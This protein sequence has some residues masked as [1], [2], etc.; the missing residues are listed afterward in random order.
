[1]LLVSC[2]GIKEVTEST[3]HFDE[4]AY[5]GEFVRLH[6]D[7]ESIQASIIHN[8]RFYYCFV[9]YTADYNMLLIFVS[10]SIDDT[11]IQYIRI[12]LDFYVEVA[13]FSIKDDDTIAL[14]A[15]E[16][17]YTQTEISKVIF[18]AEYDYS[19]KEL[20]RKN[21]KHDFLKSDSIFDNSYAVITESGNIA[22][23]LRDDN[24]SM[25]LYIFNTTED[26]VNELE[27]KS[28]SRKS[29]ALL[30]D[31]RV[32]AIDSDNAVTVLR[33]IDFKAK[34][35]GKAYPV[36]GNSDMNL[37]AAGGLAYDFLLSD[38][39]HLYGYTIETGEQMKILSWMECGFT[40]A[41]YSQIGALDD[42]R[43]TIQYSESYGGGTPVQ[44]LFVLN[45]VLRAGLPEQIVITL[46]GIWVTSEIK[47]VVAAFNRAH[48]NYRIDIIEYTELGLGDD[49]ESNWRHG[50][51]LLQT[52]LMTGRG[53]DIIYDQEIKAAFLNTT[54]DLYPFIDA[55][56]QFDRVD[57]FPNMLAALE[58]R[59]GTLSM[60][61]NHFAVTTIVGTAESVGHITSWTPAQ[62]LS[63]VEQSQNM[64]YPLGFHQSK[65][66]FVMSFLLYSGANFINMD[67][68]GVD[69]DND[70]FIHILETAKMLPEDNYS[71]GGGRPG[72]LTRLLEANQILSTVRLTEILDFRIM[73]EYLGDSMIILGMPSNAGG[74]HA[75]SQSSLLGINA[76]SQHSD[77]AWEFIRGFLLPSA[78][79]N[80]WQG[81]PLRIDLF[82]ALIKDAKTPILGLDENGNTV[83]VP[84][85][86]MFMSTS[87]SLSSGDLYNL[88][89]YAL[90]E[91]QA[92]SL[93][94]II[95]SAKSRM[96]FLEPSLTDLISEDLNTY[97]AGSRTVQETV[98]IMQNR[99]ATY[100]SEQELINR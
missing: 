88:K 53:P 74:M 18:Y 22:L 50:H 39:Q 19:G 35:W 2:G 65:T 99:I 4:Y 80:N 91:E 81:F 58:N 48:L 82:E 96:R 87:M 77:V 7:I 97:F 47:S 90:A 45:T 23:T 78:K 36:A 85:L 67:I 5:I 71:L 72:E 94:N 89:I 55:D 1:M 37:F 41:R 49:W 25:Y 95:E 69:L 30:Q 61:S 17:N 64:E 79:V 57:F 86:G 56:P 70:A 60:L 31:E 13:G 51:S 20:Y 33:E 46:G 42:G 10:V 24:N 84:L 54:L 76:A 38:W 9:E 100:L 16:F 40:E 3:S 26:A 75:L 6:D 44:E 14:V 8:N 12:P 92:E 52:E 62:L 11:D 63:I 34:D 21:Y 15:K 83:E 28:I 93:R 98:R 68:Y 27:L 66:R 73:S 32:F 59:D 29:I 43:I